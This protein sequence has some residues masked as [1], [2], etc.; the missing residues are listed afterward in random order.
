MKK[1]L[2]AGAAL[3]IGALS[4]AAALA[5]PAASQTILIQNA[6]LITSGPQGV[7]ENGDVLL[8]DGV[9]AGVGVDL[10]AV[11]RHPVS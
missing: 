7:I 8:R 6:R 11:R 9:I 5:Q 2:L 3:A 1:F 4:S 10:A